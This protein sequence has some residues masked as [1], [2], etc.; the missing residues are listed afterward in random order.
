MMVAMRRVM[1]A[2]WVAVCAVA[3]TAAAGDVVHFRVEDTIQPA[4][5]RFIERALAE[6]EQR[7]AALVVMEL[8]TPGGLLDAT[9]KITTAVSGSKVPVAVYVAPAGARAARDRGQQE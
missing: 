9:R 2:S 4:S 5:Q 7:G 3:A 8:D 6:A 1:L